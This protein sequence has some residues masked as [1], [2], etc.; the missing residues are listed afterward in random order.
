MN[1][2]KKVI[3]V[4]DKYSGQASSNHMFILFEGKNEAGLYKTFNDDTGNFFIDGN[5]LY[6]AS[7]KQIIIFVYN[8]YTFERSTDHPSI[9]YQEKILR[10]YNAIN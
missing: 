9:I 8:K 1:N 2:N 3:L 10:V 6:L 7:L 5:H 4:Y